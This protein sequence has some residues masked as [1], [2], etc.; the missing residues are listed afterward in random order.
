MRDILVNHRECP[1]D[2]RLT[3]QSGSQD[4]THLKEPFES[5][6]GPAL[7][8]T[9]K[10]RK[11]VDINRGH[12]SRGR[13]S[14]QH[15]RRPRRQPARGEQRGFG[16]ARHGG[17]GLVQRCSSVFARCPNGDSRGKGLPAIDLGRVTDLLSC[18]VLRGNK[19]EDACAGVQTT[20]VQGRLGK[21]IRLVGLLFQGLESMIVCTRNYHRK[22]TGSRNP[23]SKMAGDAEQ[24]PEEEHLESILPNFHFSGFPIFAVM[25]ESL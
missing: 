22:I 4:F 19:Q 14:H 16:L 20:R 6:A 11:T 15:Q 24:P 18:S 7:H 12:E 17:A 8:H 9:K 25:L 13:S 10:G 1:V 2:T 5:G 21:A 23:K 3:I